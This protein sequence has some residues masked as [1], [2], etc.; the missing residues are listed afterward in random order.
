MNRN[1][2]GILEKLPKTLDETYER[3]LKDIS[4]D[5]KEHARR[6]LHCLAVAIRPLCVEELAEILAFDFEGA[7][8]GIPKFCVDWRSKDQEWAVLSTCSSLISVVDSYIWGVGMCRVVQFSHFSV[9][10]FL[11]SDRLASSARDVSRYHILPRLAHTILVQ[12]CLGY[13]LHLGTP[14]DR[15]DTV[16]RFP[17]ARYAAEYWVAHAQF[18]DVVSHVED[19]MQ[20]LFDPDKHHLEAW[21]LV[22]DIETCDPRGSHNPSN[23]LYY[24]ALCGFHD[25]VEHFVI[26]HPQLTNTFGGRRD[27]P[28]VLAALSNNHIRVAEFLV[29]HGGKV[30]IQGKKGP[31]L[32]QMSLDKDLFDREDI[33]VMVS[34]LI[35]HGADVNGWSHLYTP[36]HDAIRFRIFE[37]V[38]LL[39]ENGADADSRDYERRTPLHVV[40]TEFRPWDDKGEGSPVR[41][42]ARL[43]LERGANVNAQD[44]YGATPLLMAAHCGNACIAEV[45]LEHGADINAKNNYRQTSLHLLVENAWVS[46]PHS[47]H[48]SLARL[49]LRHGANVNDED[50]DHKT[51]LH[52]AALWWSFEIAQIL[53]D[54]N[55]R[56]T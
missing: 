23:P 55:I 6:L 49:L 26:T 56:K 52:L 17:L 38:P 46:S 48:C 53:L 18:E 33:I 37:L 8:G 51:P 45:L 41:D 13:L 36:L 31:T 42:I 9:K 14:T 35:R 27:I 15:D 22:Y 24:A 30:D 5:N 44:K 54:H 39:L 47:H 10:E 21:L 25:V 4:E 16:K 7:E 11:V 20:S 3:V 29:Q 19:G 50:E 32:L 43:L 2:R 40:T 12:T 34:F 28:P 1:L